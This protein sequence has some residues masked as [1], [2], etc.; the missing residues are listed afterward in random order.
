[1]IAST[2]HLGIDVGS[3]TAKA[4]VFDPLAQ[5][6]LFSRYVRHNAHQVETVATLLRTVAKEFPECSFRL[7]A[8][9]S[10]GTTI[11]DVLGVPFVQEVVANSLAVRRDHEN[12]RCAIELGGQDAKMVFFERDEKSGATTV[13]DMRTWH[14]RRFMPSQ[15][16]RSAAWRRASTSIRPSSSRAAR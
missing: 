5:R 14:C 9:G 7:V 12:V 6:V 13:A 1:M 11:A 10:G 4:V 15:S 16:R 3:T 2:Y 8:C